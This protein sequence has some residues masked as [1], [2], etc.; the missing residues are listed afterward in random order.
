MRTWT[1]QTQSSLLIGLALFLVLLI[2]ILIIQYRRFGGLSYARVLGAGAV[3]VYGVA[4]F[5]FTML[6]VPDIDAAWCAAHPKA[7]FTQPFHSL[8]EIRQAT[9]GMGWGQSLQTFTVLQVLFNVLL[10]IPFGVLARGYLKIH[11]ALAILLGVLTSVLIETTQYTGFWGLFPCAWRVA[12]VDDVITNSLGTVIGVALAPLVLHWMP[13]HDELADQRHVP[14]Q[15]TA[16]RRWFGQLLDWILLGIVTTTVVVAWNIA[17]DVG[18][19]A[20][21]V[22]QSPVNYLP[23]EADGRAQ[24]LVS[25][26]VAAL[27]VFYLP[28]LFGS[29]ASLGKRAV[30]LEP[31]WRGADGSPRRGSLWQRLLRATFSGG[32]FMALLGAIAVLA[33]ENSQTLSFVSLGLVGLQAVLVALSVLCVPFTR[34]KRGLGGLL[35]GSDLADPRSP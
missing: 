6:P 28:A 17:R 31:V 4:L 14:R 34:D 29:G 5:V 24:N 16:M 2:P 15:I 20:D 33:P 9:A 1:W 11:W 23:W 12:D 32:L 18:A 13:S 30:W 21:S 25:L 26:G 8:D 35:T 19:Y 10:F 3:A 27:V 22:A 7:V